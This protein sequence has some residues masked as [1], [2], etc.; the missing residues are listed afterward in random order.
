MSSSAY[1]LLI[2]TL[3]PMTIQ[4]RYK[5]PFR[6]IYWAT[7]SFGIEPYNVETGRKAGKAIVR[8]VMHTHVPGSDTEAMA[9]A[10]KIT[11]RLNAG[12]TYGGPKTLRFDQNR[13]NTPQ[14]VEGYF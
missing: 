8:L 4:Y 12:G 2:L 9:V 6:N 11:E 14:S 10:D 7:L 3:N 1:F 13:K 5:L